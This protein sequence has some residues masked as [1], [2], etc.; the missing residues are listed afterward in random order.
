MTSTF[1]STVCVITTTTAYICKVKMDPLP[2]CF[3]N[4]TFLDDF[5][6]FYV[7]LYKCMYY[8]V[9]NLV[10]NMSK[11]FLIHNP[12]GLLLVMHIYNTGIKLMNIKNE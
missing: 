12:F 4:F 3:K 8:V 7:G 1:V 10:C 6:S 9:L 11:V 2:P 5:F